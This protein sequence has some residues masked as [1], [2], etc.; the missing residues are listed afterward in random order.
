MRKLILLSFLLFL[1]CTLYSF[2]KD[3]KTV[4]YYFWNKPKCISCVKMEKFTKEAVSEINNGSIEY[5]VINFG[6]NQN[7][8]Y[9]KKYG[10]Y[11]KTVILSK[12]KDGKEIKHKNL[13]Q[14]WV[15]LNNEQDFKQ[16]IKDEI[17]KF[18]E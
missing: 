16:Y 11:T 9:V 3:T 15:K 7:K 1:G 4:V 12:V 10:L 5:K 13:T 2:A 14:V 8:Q 17:Q 6:K 18:M